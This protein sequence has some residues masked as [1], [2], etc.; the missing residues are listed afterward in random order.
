MKTS[1]SMKIG[2]SMAKAIDRRTALRGALAGTAVVLT[3]A[4]TGLPGLGNLG[5][6]ALGD[7]L[8]N[9]LTASSTNAFSRLT[10]SD[11]FF[12]QQVAKLGG[13]NLLGIGGGGLSG[14]LGTSLVKNE[15]N[16]LVAD[17]AV[18][19]A[20]RAAPVVADAVK[21]MSVASA[22]E[23]LNGGPQAA[24]GFLRSELGNGL[25]EAMV[26]ELGSAMRVT[27]NPIIGQLLS[28]VAGVNVNSAAQ[29]LSNSVNNTIWQEIGIEEAAIRADPSK[30]NN[31]GLISIFG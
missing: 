4:C 14:L 11:G 29:S 16:G 3:P 8:K 13:S 5:D 15:L 20:E 17:F 12:D 31:A 21:N 19:G 24:T 18:K 2:D 7:I 26:P 25:I 9:L 23:L 22:A 10:Q 1:E 30:T 27:S 6:F 28:S